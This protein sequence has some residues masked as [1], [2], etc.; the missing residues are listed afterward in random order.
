V[1]RGALADRPVVL[2]AAS[3]ILAAAHDNAWVDTAPL[4][5]DVDAANAACRTVLL[6]LAAV[7]LHTACC[8]VLGVPGEAVV[9]D[10]GAVVVVL[11]T[12]RVRAAL[13]IATGV[14]TPVLALHRM[15]DLVVSTIQVV[16]TSRRLAA[17]LWVLC[18]SFES[19]ETEALP[20]RTDS[21]RSTLNVSAQVCLQG[22]LRE[23]LLKRISFVA[24]LTPA[25]VA[26]FCVDTDG[27]LSADVA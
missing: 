27:V 9:T 11:D 5:A 10:A 18:I 8:K 6:C 21:I 23:T 17:F 20:H 15:A 4:A 24:W 16:G 7:F 25:V 13:N 26:S 12:T 22:L 1:G 3:L 14:H 2:H 19:W